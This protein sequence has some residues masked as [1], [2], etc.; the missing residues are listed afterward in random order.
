MTGLTPERLAEIAD[1]A[2][3]W[4]VDSSGTGC[5]SGIGRAFDDLLA[6]VKRLRAL[7]DQIAAYHDSEAR[8]AAAMEWQAVVNYHR[9]RARVARGQPCAAMREP[10]EARQIEEAK[11]GWQMKADAE[12]KRATFAEMQLGKLAVILAELEAPLKN[13]IRIA[14]MQP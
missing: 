1:L 9:E 4:K 7:L 8:E 12:R 2:R 11:E 5:W 3:T 14:R 13:A 10:S 6:E